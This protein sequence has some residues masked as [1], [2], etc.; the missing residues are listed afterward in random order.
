MNDGRRPK[1]LLACAPPSA[2]GMSAMRVMTT[3]CNPISPPVL[4]VTDLFHPVDNLTVELFLNSDVRHGCGRH[5]PMPVL[6]AGRDPDHITG[7]DLLDRSAFALDPA[8]P[9]RDDKSL[10]EWMRMPCS[11][12]ARLESY[13]GTLN[14]CRIGCLK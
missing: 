4:L 9:S 2:I 5:G 1:P 11:A 8:A 7:P 14:E 12:R 3:N 13:A 6:L 10:T